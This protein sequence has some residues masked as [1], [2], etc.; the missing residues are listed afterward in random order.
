MKIVLTNDADHDLMEIYD[1]K[2]SNF[3]EKQADIYFNRLISFFDRLAIYPEL[4]TQREELATGVKS[5]TVHSHVNFYQI[6]ND[7]ILVVRT[8]HHSRDFPKHIQY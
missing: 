5:L 2:L 4:G 8:L 3:G 1:Y 6:L 7:S